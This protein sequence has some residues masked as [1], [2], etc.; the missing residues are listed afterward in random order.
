M[1]A[2]SFVYADW[3][4]TSQS[5]FKYGTRK[6]AI[7]GGG[8]LSFLQKLSNASPAVMNIT[9]GQTEYGAGFKQIETA[10]GMLDYFRSDLLTQDSKYTN[11]MFIIDPDNVELV[12]YRDLNLEDLP[13]TKDILLKQWIAQIGLKVKFPERHGFAYLT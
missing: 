2:S 10:H 5:I 13:T 4:D 8:M 12:V 6:M 9:K 1:S 7:G 3:I 11:T